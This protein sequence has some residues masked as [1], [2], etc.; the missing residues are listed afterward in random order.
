LKT[1]LQNL[2]HAFK[3]HQ[4]DAF[5]VTKDE[6]I[7][8]LTGYPSEESW[9]LVC[10]KES[11]YLTDGRHS[12][13]AKRF[14]KD[15]Q[16]IECKKSIFDE[17]AQIVEAQG[18]RVVGFDER[19]MTVL[20]FKRIEQ[21]LKKTSR[22]LGCQDLVENIRLVKRND[23]LLKMTKALKFH[24]KC[25]LYLK[26]IIKPGR[27]ENQVF[28]Q[29]ERYVRAHHVSFSFSTIIASGV[30]SCFPHARIT[31]RKI[32]R[33]DLVLVDMGIDVEGYKSDL[34]RMFFLGK[35]PHRMREVY[36]A[37]AHAKSLAIKKIKPGVLTKDID[38]E[39]RN[40]LKQKKLD[41]YFSHSLGH[42]IGLEVHEAPGIS[43][44]S[45]AVVQKGMV[46]TIE[47]GVYL[48]GQFGIRIEDMIQVTASGHKI[49]SNF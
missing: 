39:A 15:I 12:L 48:P 1:P 35:I 2:L 27:S 4:I 13:H 33:E 36:D 42:G 45:S 43:P 24:K 20:S 28:E 21:A 40:F 37:V 38:A 30:N 9:L 31:D 6:N 7:F 14:L 5:L 3:K 34:T 23:E 16:V 41:R 10:P 29:L 44:K 26:Q 18:S 25:L 32:R 17:M 47:P 46:F 11:F 22:L 49:L 19:H 8:Y